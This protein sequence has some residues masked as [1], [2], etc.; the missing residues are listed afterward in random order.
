MR[1]NRAMMAQPQRATSRRNRH[2]APGSR[3]RAIRRPGETRE[4]SRERRAA[5]EM[6]P[7]VQ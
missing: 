7:R 4:I 5:A 6:I 1:K 3:R 2:D